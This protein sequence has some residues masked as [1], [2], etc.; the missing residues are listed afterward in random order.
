MTLSATDGYPITAIRYASSGQTR[1]HLIVAGEVGVPQ[2]FYRRF[3]E[4]A[5]SIGYSTLTFDYRDIGGSRIGS[6]KGSMVRMR[7]TGWSG[8]TFASAARTD[9]A[10]DAGSE[11]DFTMT[12]IAGHV[13][14]L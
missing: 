14:W 12:V 1:A 4:Y 13:A 8:A 3:A 6:L 11:A 10:I 9:G 5:A 2:R 7:E